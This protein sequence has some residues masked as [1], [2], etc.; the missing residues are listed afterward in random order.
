MAD[1][2]RP[3]H[4]FRTTHW[5]LVLEAARADAPERESALAILCQDYWYPLYA[6]VRRQ[7]RNPQ[8]A[9]DLTQEFLARL[10]ARN[11]LASVRP[12]HGR[13]RSFLLAALKNFLANDWD[14]QRAVK[15]GGRHRIVSWDGESAESRYLAEPCHEATPERI[16][17]RSWALSVIQTVLERL[18]QEYADSGKGGVFDS[19]QSCLEEESEETYAQIAARLNLS[20]G[21]VK[22]AVF[23]L[24]KNF[25]QRLRAEIARTVADP[26]AIDEELRHLFTCLGQ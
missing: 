26:G 1:P 9:E 7:G 3:A 20:E 13:F 24:R 23:R 17:E 6:F 5:S 15:R 19:I 2:S 10:V 18:R 11:G 25:R 16:Y 8:E 14:R 4:D 21:A 22:M 12:E